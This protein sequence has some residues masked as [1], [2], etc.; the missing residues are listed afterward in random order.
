MPLS[1]DLY[2]PGLPTIARDLN[3]SPGAAQY[4]LAVF[5]IGAAL[6]QIAYGPITDKYGR[7]KPLLVGLWIYTIGAT[8]CA[9]AP[10]ISVLI[11]GRF[12]QAF[13][14]SAGAVIAIAVAR[15]L[16]SGK[17]LA[18]RL[19]LLV[20]VLGVAPILAPS[21]GG[22]IFTAWDWHG[23]F[24]FLVAYGVLVTVA[25]T[26]LPETSASHERT[27]A[28][29]R[30]ATTT[31]AM[32]LRNTPFLLYVLTGACMV[33]TLLAYITG[34]AFIYIE[35]LG[36]TPGLFAVLF[37]VNAI[38]FVGASQLNRLLLRRLSMVSVIRGAVTA[39]VLIGMG[40]LVVVASG[41]ASTLTLTVLFIAQA[42]TVGAPLPNVTAL[43]FGSVRERMGSAAALQGTAQSVVAGVA[44]W[45]VGMLGNGA[46]L[47]VM[48][49]IAGFA[50]LAAVLLLAAHRWQPET[51]M[52][53]QPLPDLLNE[54]R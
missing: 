1:T 32:L 33:G 51:D 37:G 47:P 10:T 20:L 12:L 14:A 21:L 6:G 29:L 4:T 48:G 5:M 11:G 19:S 13:G 43:A 7:K 38:G 31:Y 30:D 50:A 45:L 26:L 24:W 23:L 49:I 34:S 17:V 25:V 2:L 9:L 36:V 41:H 35:T 27:Q 28:R 8:I 52:V 42:A 15:D 16:W 54:Q 53:P 18:D 46:A 40:L 22:F 3:V 39:A 44:G